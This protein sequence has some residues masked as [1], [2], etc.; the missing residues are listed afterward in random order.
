MRLV[1]NPQLGIAPVVKQKPGFN[2]GMRR[3]RQRNQKISARL[4]QKFQ[5]GQN[6]GGLPQM[7]QHV[8]AD[9]NVK[10]LPKPRIVGRGEIIQVNLQH[11]V[12]NPAFSTNFNTFLIGFKSDTAAVL[13]LCQQRGQ[14]AAGTADVKHPAPGLSHFIKQDIAVVSVFQ[15]NFADIKHLFDFPV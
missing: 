3:I 4:Q 13:P 8:A 7:F 12:E 5:L 9:N 6:R 11:F 1:Q 15:I 2:A 14:I 10:R